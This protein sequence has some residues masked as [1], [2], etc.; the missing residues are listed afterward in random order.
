[1]YVGRGEGAI[2]GRVTTAGSSMRTA[3]QSSS[4]K[5]VEIALD[6]GSLL[7]AL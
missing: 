4:V 1:M 3:G 2:L 6:L 7:I 5:L